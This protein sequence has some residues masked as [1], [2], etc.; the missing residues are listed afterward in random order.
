ME[1]PQN[2]YVVDPQLKKFLENRLKELETLIDGALTKIDIEALLDLE[3]QHQILAALWRVLDCTA[4][5]S[6]FLDRKGIQP[7]LRPS[8]LILLPENER[9]LLIKFAAASKS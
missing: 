7:V 6:S 3:T 1:D 4:R 9:S 2:G 5:D 8:V